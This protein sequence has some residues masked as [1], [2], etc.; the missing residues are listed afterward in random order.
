MDPW[1]GGGVLRAP[2]D[3]IVIVIILDAAHHLDLRKAHP[4]HPFSVVSAL[5]KEKQAIHKWIDHDKKLKKPTKD[6]VKIKQTNKL[7]SIEPN[8]RN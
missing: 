1:S 2:N 4:D 5:E 7:Y 8:K 6:S 3:K